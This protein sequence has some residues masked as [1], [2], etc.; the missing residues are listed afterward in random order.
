MVSNLAGYSKV[1]IVLELE[2]RFDKEQ[3][4]VQKLWSTNLVAISVGVMSSVAVESFKSDR[5]TALFLL[6]A[7]MILIV[8]G[9]LL[10]LVS[11][12]PRNVRRSDRLSAKALE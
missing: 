12:P 8:I 2:D 6:S 9:W 7:C 11:K 4:D 10:L 1:G 5:W 3:T